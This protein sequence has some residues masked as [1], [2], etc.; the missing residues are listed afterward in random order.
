MPSAITHAVVGACAGVAVSN[1]TTP[2]RLWAFSILCAVLPDADV[3]TF[4][5]G[6]RY[7]DLFGHR[8][9][10]HSIIFALFA[11]LFLVWLFFRKS[12]TTTFLSQGSYYLYFSTLILLHG[13]LDAFTNGGEGVAFLAPF[14]NER[15]FF[16]FTPIEVSPVNLLLFFQEHRASLILSTELV[17]VWA[18]MFAAALLV[19]LL[20][21]IYRR[22]PTLKRVAYQEAPRD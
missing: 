15:I 11:A 16:D 21:F 20:I 13:V 1:G 6:I 3:I 19:R 18:P 2:K 14:S 17:W 5:F 9:F 22:R 12:Q 4:L 7:E 10:F 8:G